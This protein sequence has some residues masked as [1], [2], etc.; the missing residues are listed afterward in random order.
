MS[1]CITGS[2]AEW[3][4]SDATSRKQLDDDIYSA[5][6]N[7]KNSNGLPT[8]ISKI[9]VGYLEND[10]DAISVTAKFRGRV[11]ASIDRKSVV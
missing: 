7:A 9:V 2:R 8:T 1:V 11:I 3:I 4:S 5:I 10:P 6:G